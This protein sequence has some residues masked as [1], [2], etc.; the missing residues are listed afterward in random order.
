MTLWALIAIILGKVLFCGICWCPFGLNLECKMR[1]TCGRGVK[2]QGFA[3]WKNY[4]F[5]VFTFWASFSELLG[6]F[7]VKLGLEVLI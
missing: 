2:N 1:I 4:V 5:V 7:Y 3:F 6:D